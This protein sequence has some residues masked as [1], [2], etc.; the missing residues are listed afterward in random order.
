MVGYSFYTIGVEARKHAS[1]V[2]I[3]T[4]VCS[5]AACVAVLC[6]WTQA[7]GEQ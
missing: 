6:C 3:S 1:I 5:Q 2:D 7:A 4:S